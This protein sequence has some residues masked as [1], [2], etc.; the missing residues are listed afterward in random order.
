MPVLNRPQVVK[1][2]GN[3]S[4][5][6]TLTTGTP[7]GCVLSPMLFSLFT[8]DCVSCN[9]S[10]QILKCA[11]DTAVP[12]LVTN[13]DESEYRNQVNKLISG[14]SENNLEL[15][16]NKKQKKLSWILGER[17]LLSSRLF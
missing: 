2:D 14:C 11:D 13:S 4:S 12:G 17:N 9:E 6:L 1:I 8:Y 5:S 16:V 3:L 15:K 10:T 7:Q